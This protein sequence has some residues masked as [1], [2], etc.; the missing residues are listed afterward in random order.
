M[1]KQNSLIVIILIKVA[2]MVRVLLSL[3]YKVS[4][5]GYEILKN[6]SPL[7]ILPNHPALIDPF[8]IMSQIF[9]YTKAIPVVSSTYYDIPLARSVFNELGAVRVSNLEAGSRNINVLNE[10]TRSALKAFNRRKSLLLYPG[11]QLAGQGY[12]K[13]YNKKSAHKIILKIPEDVKVI[14]LRITGLWGSIFTK[15]STGKSPNLFIQL[16][17]G[18][19]YI[20]ANLIF[21]LPRRKVTIEIEDITFRAKTNAELGIKSFNLFL[22][23]FYNIHGEE[24]PNFLR[25]FFILPNKKNPAQGES[26][27]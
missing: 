4:V 25:H 11:G 15:A 23:D 24:D 27:A 10:I 17:K 20:L 16:T 5:K 13:I 21:F 3:R 7:L 12:E 1:G 9:R 6:S 2:A 8:I 26:P 19:I 22:E 18:F 14:G